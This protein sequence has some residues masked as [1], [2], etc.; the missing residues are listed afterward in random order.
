VVLRPTASQDLCQR[1]MQ[2]L[3]ELRWAKAQQSCRFPA[4]LMTSLTQEAWAFAHPQPT[5]VEPPV[6]PE[7]HA[8][9]YPQ[10]L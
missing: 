7:L 6:R 4:P 2:G 10:F 1:R 9:P 8:P 3:E 5:L